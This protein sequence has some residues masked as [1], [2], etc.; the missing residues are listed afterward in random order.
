MKMPNNAVAL[1]EETLP[2]GWNWSHTLKRGTSLEIT[3]THGGA[4]VAL[5]AYNPV[6]TLERYNMPDTAKIQFVAQLT[7][8]NVLY[9]DMGRIFLSVLDDTAGG[10][11]LFGGVLSQADLEARYGKRPYQE[12]RNA[13]HR[14]GRLALVTELAKYGMDDR[15]LVPNVNFFCKTVADDQGRLK[16]V[17]NS[18]AGA[19]VV[20]QAEMD[21]LVIVAATQ[22]PFDDRASWSPQPVKLRILDTRVAPRDNPCRV[23][24][25]QNQRGFANTA[26][27]QL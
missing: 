9:S 13:Y 19:R 21:T 14:S 26:L 8:G 2:G 10:H 6:Q 7:A 23:F 1:Y 11:D 12:H 25:A 3:D 27:Y 16:L 15:D 20:L 24:S 18:R 5:L 22:H 17:K 4:C